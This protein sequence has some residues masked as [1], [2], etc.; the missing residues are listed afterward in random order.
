MRHKLGFEV[1]EINTYNV[2]L[3]LLFFYCLIYNLF[4][5]CKIENN[6]KKF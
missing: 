1:A 4:K 3:F 2:C 5:F 6:L